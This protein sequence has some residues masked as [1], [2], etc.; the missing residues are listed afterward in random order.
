MNW[1]KLKE[2]FPNSFNA[3]WKHHKQT[4]LK[5]KSCLYSFLNKQG[6]KDNLLRINQLK[7]FEN[8]EQ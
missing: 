4:A 1:H 2:K 8:K 3:I 7:D 6:Y 5:V